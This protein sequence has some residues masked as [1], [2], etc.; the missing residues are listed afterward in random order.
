MMSLL[1]RINDVRQLL[2][3]QCVLGALMAA[4]DHVAKGSMCLYGEPSKSGRKTICLE[5][6][7]FPD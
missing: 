7:H 1:I 3:C 6:F 2:P 5:A 4:A